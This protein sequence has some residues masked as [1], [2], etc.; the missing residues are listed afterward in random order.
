MGNF[1]T[2]ER[3]A[4][5]V[6][7]RLNGAPRSTH[8]YSAGPANDR[9]REGG[10]ALVLTLVVIV[11]LSIMTEMM[12]R[13]ISA[14]LDQA[15][16]NR[17]EVDAERQIAEAAAVSLYILGTRPF[18]FRGIES[19]SITQASTV[20]E[21]QMIAGFD[22]NASHIRL[23]DYPY[24]FGDAVVRFQDAR[25]LINLNLG[26]SG[27]LFG[28]LGILEVPADDRGPLIAK[29]QDYIDADS[30]TRLNGAEAPEYAD[31]GREPPANAPLRT[32]W[33]VRRILDWDK[34]GGIAREDTQ[35]ALL[36]TTASV[37][38]FNV[39]TAPRALLSV[40]PGISEG[41]VDNVVRWRHEQPIV[42]GYQ[43][44]QLA[45]LPI[46]QGPSRFLGLPANSILITLSSPHMPLERRI[47]VRLTPGM[48]DRPW[49]IDYDVEMPPASRGASETKP[50]ALPIPA[51]L[52]PVP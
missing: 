42:T 33:E 50:D 45:G 41:G 46:P 39:N 6:D 26:S 1:L 29:L 25:G 18:S 32:P 12:T 43:F 23:D 7:E 44:G 8:R 4:P 34:A 52:S 2:A 11:A 24:R 5:C 51:I 49:A 48:S 15:F 37:D 19:L 38:G 17:E 28:L 16:A 31:A 36:A 9:A 3:G 30:L 27:D 14:A 20:H 10:F 40:M 47:A 21:P 13:W 35:W 22:P